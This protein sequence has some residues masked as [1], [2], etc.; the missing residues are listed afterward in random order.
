MIGTDRILEGLLHTLEQSVLPSVAGGFARG[1]LQAVLEVLGNL[2]G[3]LRWGGMLLDQEAAALDEVL[4]LAASTMQGDLG[5]RCAAWRGSAAGPLDDARMHEGRALLCA[6]LDAGHA[7]AG[8]LAAAV[9]A[10]LAN[11]AIF[12][13]MA[14]RPSRL[15]EI[16]QG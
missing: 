12:K 6:L 14:L 5:V 11:D 2:Q 4:G 8:P 10:W 3:Q 15:A 7:D 1:Q 13:A 9:D 16:S